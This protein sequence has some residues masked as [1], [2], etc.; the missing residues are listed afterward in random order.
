[1]QTRLK[2][3][4]IGAGNMGKKHVCVY[5]NLPP[6]D[7]VAIADL[8]E[9]LAKE[10]ADVYKIRFYK[11]YKEMLDIEAPDIVSICVPTSLHYE[12]AKICLEKKINTLLE[13]PITTSI[14]DGEKL[15]AQAKKN[16]V[17]FL[18]GHIERHNPA[19]KKVKIL[20]EKGDLGKIT[21]IIARRVGGFP[22][23]IR[24]AN[25]MVDLAIHDIDIANYLL[26]ELPQEI[27]I[28][29][30]RHHIEQREDAVEFF[31]K[32]KNASAYIQANWITPVKIRKLNI[33]GTEGYIEMDY[34]TQKV[35]FYK[36]NYKKFREAAKGFS[37]YILHFS[38]PDK[39]DIPI[40]KNEPLKE[41]IS[42]FVN[43]VENNLA[44]D[45]QFALDALKIALY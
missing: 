15:L 24:D 34:I 39:I 11:D 42:Y 16:K 45:S 43:C 23:R 33:T 12:V 2:C 27:F 20:I 5:A 4:V 30:K 40:E 17:K 37:D 7:L 25:I 26:N 3:A 14:A 29:K 13:K 31:L 10:V 32:Y 38:E 1:M 22:Y 35:E 18:V 9:A 44:V 6:V 28:N 21:A 19:I 41:E 8:N 36:S